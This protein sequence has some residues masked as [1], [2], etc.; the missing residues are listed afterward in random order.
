MLLVVT[1]TGCKKE[2]VALEDVYG[3]YDFIK[4]VY[5]NQ[6]NPLDK[7][8]LNEKYKSKA[9]YSV[10]E[11]TFAFYETDETT[12][13]ISLKLINYKDVDI[14]DGIEEKEVKTLL[15]GA[16]TRYDIYKI[17]V[18]QGYSFVFTDE[19]IYFIEFRKLTA[20]FRVVWHIFEIEKR[21]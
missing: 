10:K 20:D 3:K 9:R 7:V 16:S 2:K 5:T 18:S 12:P 15:K 4:C 11:S 17:D 21:D 6:Q 14:N 19:T 8:Q 13:T 1:L